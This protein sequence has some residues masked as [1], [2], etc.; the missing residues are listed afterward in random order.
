MEEWNHK[1]KP[2]AHWESRNV[3]PCSQELFDFELAFATLISQRNNEPLLSSIKN[4]TWM[5]KNS[6][7][8]F[9]RTSNKHYEVDDLPQTIDILAEF[10]YKRHMGIVGKHYSA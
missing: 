8:Q 1:P 3:I 7:F 4:Y 5:L 10:A 9:D 2:G 6:L